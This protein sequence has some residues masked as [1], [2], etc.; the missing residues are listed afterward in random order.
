ARRKALPVTRNPE[1]RDQ[2]PGIVEPVVRLDRWLD[3]MQARPHEL[4]LWQA[5][6]R[7]DA[8][9]PRLPRLGEALRPADEPVRVT[10]PAGLDFAAAPVSSMARAPSHG[11]VVLGQ[12]VFGLL[13]PNGPLPL[14]LTELAHERQ[15]RHADR[16]LQAFLDLLTQ[17]FSM[18]FYRAW[19]QAQPVVG[20]DRPGIPPVHRWLGS[21]AGIGLEGLLERDDLG[22]AAKL[23]FTRRLAR[24]ARGAH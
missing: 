17:R 10:Q 23:H 14:H 5:L 21:L 18:L 20:L 16:T 2:P 19:A 22:D 13:G 9:H 3:D 15:L 11:R 7:I 24:Q 4:D 12:R 6:R 8:A 1:H